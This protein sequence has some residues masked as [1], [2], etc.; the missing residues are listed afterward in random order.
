VAIEPEEDIPEYKDEW[1]NGRS[2]EVYRNES[3]AIDFALN[4]GFMPLSQY[5]GVGADWEIQCLTCKNQFTS[6]YAKIRSAKHICSICLK[7]KRTIAANDPSSEVFKVLAQRELEPLEEYS[8]NSANKLMCK[9]LKCGNTVYPRYYDLLRGK[10]GC[11]DCGSRT[12]LTEEKMAEIAAV[13]KNA[14]LQP[15]V[16]Y[17]TSSVP[18]ESIC[19][20][21]GEKVTPSFHNVRR[22]H[23]GCI[24][25]Q[26]HSF[27]HTKPAYFYIMEHPELGALK[28]GVGNIQSNP[29]RIKTHIKDG[30]MLFHKL[31]FDLGRDAFALETV[32]L[33][34]FRKDLKLPPFLEQ[35]QMKK[36]G[37][38][39]TIS[40]DAL[41][42]LQIRQK[43]EVVVKELNLPVK[44]Y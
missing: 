19:L 36:A 24:Y 26:E 35:N 6:S 14:Q 34:W 38:T 9:C 5:N 43:V 11:K 32:I 16:P 29:D 22:G 15:L 20:R 10:N 4:L 39:E 25:C 30:W 1:R 23:G 44:N 12:H 8:G 37:R 18:W 21:C 27:K 13:M 41:T 2:E 42:V 40:A 17:T 7:S 33:R 31:D 28:V 3:Q